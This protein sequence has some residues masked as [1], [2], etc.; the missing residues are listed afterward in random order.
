MVEKDAQ[1]TLADQSCKNLLPD[2]S[3][4]ANVKPELLIYADDVKCS[5]GATI[6]ELDDNALFYMMQR[7]INEALARGMLVRAFLSEA[8]STLTDETLLA[9]FETQVE[10]WMSNQLGSDS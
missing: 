8:F 3:A 2:R 9:H 1:A 7:G 10:Q 6:G 5:H 4:E